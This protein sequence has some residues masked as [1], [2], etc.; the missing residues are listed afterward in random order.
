VL[1][2]LALLAAVA[3][4]VGCAPSSPGAAATA[5]ADA[6]VARQRLDAL[7]RQAVAAFT[8]QVQTTY[9]ASKR[10]VEVSATVGWTADIGIADIA[11][12]QERAK[13][14]CFRLQQALWTSGVPLRQVSAIALGPVV[15]DYGEQI[16]DAHAAARLTASTAAGFAWGTL[17]SDTAWD[18]YDEAWLRASYQPHTVGSD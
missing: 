11:K 13:T 10:M 5:T 16:V 6:A 2:A 12:A 4:L 15:N 18:R 17:T 9:D 7:A 1:T 14:I 8:T 3:A